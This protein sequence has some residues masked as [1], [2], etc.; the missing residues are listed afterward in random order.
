M[1]GGFFVWSFCRRTIVAENISAQPLIPSCGLLAYHRC[2][3]TESSQTEI[4]SLYTHTHTA[5][6]ARGVAWQMYNV[7]VKLVTNAYGQ[8]VLH[9]EYI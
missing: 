2:T 8:M 7:C 4:R 6:G 9:N 1:I 3:L 5:F